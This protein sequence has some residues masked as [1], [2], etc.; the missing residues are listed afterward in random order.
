MA[1]D[2]APPLAGVPPPATI[3]VYSRVNGAKIFEAAPQEARPA[4]HLVG[5]KPR[6]KW[7]ALQPSRAAALIRIELDLNAGDVG[8]DKEADVDTGSRR[9]ARA[10]SRA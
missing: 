1:P 4:A 8:G 7:S 9:I 2:A 6:H 10:S 5:R 3:A